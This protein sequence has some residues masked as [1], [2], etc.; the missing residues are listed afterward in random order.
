M[1]YDSRMFDE[2]L[3]FTGA[4][5]NQFYTSWF[6]L[7]RFISESHFILYQNIY[8]SNWTASNLLKK[9]LKQHGVKFIFAKIIDIILGLQC[10]FVMIQ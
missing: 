7:T 6:K 3:L 9:N 1:T 8:I 4:E 5:T 10:L 2:T